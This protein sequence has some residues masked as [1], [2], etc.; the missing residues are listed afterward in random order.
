MNHTYKRKA[1]AVASKSRSHRARSSLSRGESS[2]SKRVRFSE[3][4]EEESSRQSSR[5]WPKGKKPK[6]MEKHEELDPSGGNV[7]PILA[8]SSVIGLSSMR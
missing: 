1:K 6:W 2:G 3:N 4:L 7:L 8:M 5:W